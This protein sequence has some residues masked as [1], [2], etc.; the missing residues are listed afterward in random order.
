MSK[1][2][3]APA[4]CRRA[5]IAVGALVLV[6]AIPSES[7][8]TPVTHVL[9]GVVTYANPFLAPQISAG[10][11]VTYQIVF[12]AATADSTPG[13]DHGRYAGAFLSVSGTIGTYAFSGSG[14]SDIDIFNDS[15]SFS[16]SD[17]IGLAPMLFTGASINGYTPN[18]VSSATL[19][20]PSSL[21]A[22]D[23]LSELPPNLSNVNFQVQ[24]LQFLGPSGTT[25]DGA[26]VDWDLGSWRAASA[27]VPEPSGFFLFASGLAGLAG[28]A[29]RA[30]RTR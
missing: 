5:F 16:G 18:I 13:P 26:M 17:L 19:G 14:A 24:F 4:A 10:D 9:T 11:L 7:F 15:P 1:S 8:A 12:E 2:L 3:R 29:W 27:A 30:R 20:G 21:L 25:G 28:A 22:T 6:S 23:S